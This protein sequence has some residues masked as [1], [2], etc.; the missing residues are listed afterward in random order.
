MAKTSYDQQKLEEIMKIDFGGGEHHPEIDYYWGRVLQALKE[1]KS[2]SAV[3][4][5]LAAANRMSCH[6]DSDSVHGVGELH[7]AVKEI[8][9]T[10]LT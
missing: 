9:K 3:K 1:G 8:L 5:R 7:R 10:A 2:P 4:D 6:T